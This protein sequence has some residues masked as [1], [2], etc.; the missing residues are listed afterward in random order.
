[1]FN[2]KPYKIYKNI[3]E[4]IHPSISRKN[5][6]NYQV[7]LKDELFPIQIFYPKIE[8]ELNNILIYIHGEE[9]NNSFYTDL[10]IKTN[11]IVI[12]I[13][14]SNSKDCYCLEKT[15][16]FIIRE[17]QKCNF[18]DNNI[19]ICGDFTGANNL[20]NIN[21]RLPISIRKIFLSP[22]I[23]NLEDYGLSNF[24]IISNNESKAINNDNFYLIKESIYDFIHDINL[25]TNEKIY[26]IIT[27]YLEGNR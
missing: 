16:N 3:N 27:N 18:S 19:N 17:L 24:L 23:D 25:V 7:I 14:Y 2:Q 8:T 13:D 12:L 20:L 21:D 5:I 4:I 26:N 10:A 1:M 9:I 6:S 22:N 11:Q 15:I